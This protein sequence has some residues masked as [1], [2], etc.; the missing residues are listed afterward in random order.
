[1][2]G[3]EDYAPWDID[4]DYAIELLAEI[5]AQNEKSGFYELQISV[6]RRNAKYFLSPRSAERFI[7]NIQLSLDPESDN[8]AEEFRFYAQRNKSEVPVRLTIHKDQQAV[9]P[10]KAAG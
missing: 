2:A 6:G 7:R 9:T 8:E 10:A 4:V 3:S 5:E 1:M